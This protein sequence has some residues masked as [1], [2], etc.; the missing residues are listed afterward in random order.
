MESVRSFR[1]MTVVQLRELAREKKVRLPYG[2]NKAQI[3]ELLG[4][5]L[6]PA[7]GKEWAGP[8]HEAPSGVSPAALQ[9]AASAQSGP[10]A[11]E[12]AGHAAPAQCAA[13]VGASAQC[14]PDGS[15]ACDEQ[16]G[17]DFHAAMAQ[18]NTQLHLLAETQAISVKNIL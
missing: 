13:H 14:A 11:R 4:R 10:S 15:A 16:D 17:P 12:D 3:V 1:H 9:A 18:L 2:V 7:A 8:A 6:E 5:E